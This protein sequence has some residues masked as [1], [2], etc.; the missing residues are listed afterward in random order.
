MDTAKRIS[1]ES[2]HLST[3]IQDELEARKWSLNDLASRMGEESEYGLNA[4]TLYFVWSIHDSSCK[5]GD[6]TL[7]KM[8]VALGLDF[9][10]LKN[11]ENSWHD[12]MVSHG[13][14]NQIPPREVTDEVNR[15]DTTTPQR[16]LT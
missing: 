7:K 6:E 1:A 11:L 9:Q 16:N 8:A 15:C 13:L 12:W 5:V 10:Y 14:I 3:I 2:F 4:L